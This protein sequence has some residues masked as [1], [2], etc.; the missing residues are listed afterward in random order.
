M[1]KKKIIVAFMGQAGAGKDTIANALYED[2]QKRKDFPSTSLIVSCT[3]RPPRE[4]EL[5]GVNYHF[6][7]T[8]EFGQKVLNGDMLEATCFNEWFYG[9]A[10]SALSGDINIGVFNPEGIYSLLESHNKDIYLIVYYVL[11]SG[12][13]RLLRQLNREENPDIDEILRR[14]K[15]DEIDFADL[16]DITYIP[17]WNDTKGLNLQDIVASIED[18]L[19]FVDNLL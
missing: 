14:Y 5:N 16:N 4:G 6:L 1:N 15:A 3:T 13:T 8:D 9:T 19:L 10:K 7:S 17:I 12:K 2:I 18:Q 11:A